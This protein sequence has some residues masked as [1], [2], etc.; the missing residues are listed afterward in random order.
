MQGIK[1]SNPLLPHDIGI[2]A[3]KTGLDEDVETF[4][5]I[6]KKNQ[7]L[8]A[9][10]KKPF[11]TLKMIRPG[12]PADI[13]KIKVLEGKEHTRPIRNELVGIIKISGDKLTS[14]LPENS[15]LLIT[16]KMD[17]SRRITVN[18]YIPYLDKTFD[19]V[20]D[21]SHRDSEVSQDWINETIE[22]FR[23][24]IS[25]LKDDSAEIE[26]ISYEQLSD[27][28][29]ELYD[30]EDSITKNLGDYDKSAGI[31][32]RLN[33][34]AVKLDSIE[35]NL[36]WPRTLSK[37]N[38]G[39][40]GTQDTIERYGSESEIEHFTQIQ[41]K[42]E[43]AKERKDI[44]LIKDLLTELEG[45]K[46]SIWFKQKGYWI[47]TLNNIDEYYDDINW[48]ERLRARDLLAECKLI[49]KE[50]GPTEDIEN[51]VRRL[52]ELMPETDI[53]RTKKTRDDL[54]WY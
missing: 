32:N 29:K 37:I 4:T 15:D 43:I 22:S 10:G 11:K 3:I 5:A 23:R 21:S 41:S 17:E 51:A 49:V 13:I 8:P 6:L 27:L 52:W 9:M 12:N 46:Y 19:G 53:E 40:A 2:S 7:T 14:L 54:P 18:A 16:L 1:I 42:I 34:L 20:M 50:E 30:L 36:S 47:Y 35:D 25:K 39:L 24:D 38:E 26:E 45:M 44:L 31:K 48:K 28:E 33:K